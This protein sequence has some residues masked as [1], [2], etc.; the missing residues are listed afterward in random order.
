MNQEFIRYI[1]SHFAHL[2]TADEQMAFR[3]RNLPEGTRTSAAHL[4]VLG[5]ERLDEAL[6]RINEL[7]R[8]GD[9]AF[10]QRVVQR[11][12]TEAPEKVYLNYCPKCGELA[13]TPKARQCRYC[14][15]QWHD[16][17]IA[18]FKLKDAFQLT[19]RLFYLLGEITRGEISIG[20]YIDLTPLGL[21]KKTLVEGVEFV[22][23]KKDEAIWEDIALGTSELTETEKARIKKIGS[24]ETPLDIVIER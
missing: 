7:L 15:Y 14:T 13:R 5:L 18:R 21:N 1:L 10:E 11:I 9:E 16:L 19:G 22:R 20:N 3:Y 6:P 4:K 24:F 17:T 23:M 8:E 12:M 2:M